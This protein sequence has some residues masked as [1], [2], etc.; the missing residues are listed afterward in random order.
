MT[1]HQ[2]ARLNL[3]F[4]VALFSL[5]LLVPQ[6]LK[7]QSSGWS[8]WRGPEGNGI[9]SNQSIPQ[10]WSESENVIWKVKVPGR[11]HASPIMAEGKIFLATADK[12]TQSQSV[13]AYSVESGEQLWNTEVN[14]GG[15]A[16][17]IHQ[18]NTY[19]SSTIATNGESLFVVFSH[20]D[21]V[22]VTAL[23]LDGKKLWTKSA[24]A[25]KP[26]YPFGHGASPIVYRDV[27]IV[28]NEGRVEAALVAYD[29][30]TGDVKWK[31]KREGI[32]SYS[33]PVVAELDGKDQLLISGG[34]SVSSYDPMTGDQNWS[35]S[36]NWQ[37]TCG[38][39]VWDKK[40]ELVFAS[41]GFPGN[42]TLA[43]NFKTGQKVWDNPTKVYEQSMLAHD[44][45]LYAHS[46]N[47]ALYCWDAATGKEMWR[48]KFSDRRVPVSASPILANGLIYFTAENGETAVIKATPEK[49]EEVARNQLGTISFASFAALNN[50]LYARV[51]DSKDGGRQE[52]LYCLGEK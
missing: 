1:D 2:I 14:N 42:Q 52:W 10:T 18:K 25:Y 41:G 40:N 15:L 5:T 47:G 4:F 7:G 11:G 35:T 32:S 28:P 51:A 3:L 23:D 50:R 48:Q 27:V 39:M 9:V 29:T 46:D 38:T 36:A 37:V 30:K 49:Y 20:N 12:A 8:R 31:A 34:E 43:V 24:G 17:R 21:S 45:Y 22:H 13:L 19:A 44:G 16:G 26:R 33:T 6:Q